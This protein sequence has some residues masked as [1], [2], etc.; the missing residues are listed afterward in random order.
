VCDLSCVY[1]TPYT[2]FTVAYD[3]DDDRL[4]L[5]RWPEKRSRPPVTVGCTQQPPL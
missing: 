3:F 1:D 2:I 4:F 5:R